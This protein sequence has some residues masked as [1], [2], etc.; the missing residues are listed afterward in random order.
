[1][2]NDIFLIASTIYTGGNAWS[3]TAVR[4]TYSPEERFQQSLEAIQTIR[5]KVPNAKILFVEAS[6]LLPDMEETLR[7]QV[8]YYLNTYEK[9]D[10][11]YATFTSER[12]G[13]GEVKQCIA[14]V[15]FIQENKTPFTRLFKLSGRYSLNS[16]FHLDNFSKDS[17]VLNKVLKGSV[18]HP[19]VLYSVPFCFIDKFQQILCTCNDMYE[20]GV[21]GLE[22][23]LPPLC[24]P[25]MYIPCVGT[26]GYVAV[27][28][29]IFYSPKP[30][31][32][33]D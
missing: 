2:E 16:Y 5:E 1:M 27:S 21:H 17:F 31:D 19:T 14:G 12:K 23:I 26:E 10:I 25:A 11:R 6:K 13:W 32:C 9:E 8:D 20:K 30:E 28:K 24:Q 18:C 22:V 7:Q 29:D 15:E 4:S 33:L 3:Y